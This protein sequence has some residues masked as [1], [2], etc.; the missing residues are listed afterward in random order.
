M[1][2][3]RLDVLD[4]IFQSTPQ[5]RCYARGCLSS[6]LTATISLLQAHQSCCICFF[7]VDA[8]HS[9]LAFDSCEAWFW[10]IFP[11]GMHL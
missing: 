7:Q 6:M 11:H 1:F 9:Q 5:M 10:H 8:V 4:L 3:R 2:P